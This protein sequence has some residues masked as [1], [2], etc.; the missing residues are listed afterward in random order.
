MPVSSKRNSES[1]R[2]GTK[3]RIKSLDWFSENSTNVEYT[4]FG[5][6]YVFNTDNGVLKFDIDFL[7]SLEGVDLEISLIYYSGVENKPLLYTVKDPNRD[8]SGTL[9]AVTL[10]TEDMLEPVQP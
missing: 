9:F 2:K 1:L 8:S 10:F 5:N 4:K 3:V 6:I 7:K